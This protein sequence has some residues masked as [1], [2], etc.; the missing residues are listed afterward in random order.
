MK[1]FEKLKISIDSINYINCCGSGVFIM[2]DH[3]ECL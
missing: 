3:I 1:F 2:Y